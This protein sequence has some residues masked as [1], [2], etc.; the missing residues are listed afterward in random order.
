MQRAPTSCSPPRGVAANCATRRAAGAS[1]FLSGSGCARRG[2]AERLST[3]ARRPFITSAMFGLSPIPPEALRAWATR[4]AILRIALLALGPKPGKKHCPN[5]NPMLGAARLENRLRFSS[6]KNNTAQSRTQ[7]SAPCPPHCGSA[8]AP[9]RFAVARWD[10]ISIL[11]T[12]KRVKSLFKRAGDGFFAH[13]FFFARLFFVRAPCA[14]QLY[15]ATAEIVE[16][17]LQA[18]RASSLREG[19]ALGPRGPH[20]PWTGNACAFPLAASTP[21]LCPRAGELYSRALGNLVKTCQHILTIS[22]FWRGA[23]SKHCPGWN[24]S[25]CEQKEPKKL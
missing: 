11:L 10:F 8:V 5:P 18:W 20:V 4:P 15:S 24:C 13:H 19:T 7:F 16:S 25:F 9:P 6:P 2:W 21:V 3:Q 14:I 22:L 23:R 1:L 17:L 12:A